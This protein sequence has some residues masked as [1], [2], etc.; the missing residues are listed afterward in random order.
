MSGPSQSDI[1]KSSSAPRPELDFLG[2]VPSSKEQG[3]MK[4]PQEQPLKLANQM[5]GSGCRSCC[6]CA[7]GCR[8]S[9]ST[10]TPGTQLHP[11]HTPTARGE[12]VNGC[13]GYR[14]VCS[15]DTLSLPSQHTN[16]EVLWAWVSSGLCGDP[17]WVEPAQDTAQR[18]NQQLWGRTSA[19]PGCGDF[20]SSRRPHRT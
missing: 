6:A 18:G 2:R 12:Q 17:S 11:T 4:V 15:C 5:K 14:H 8:R 13:P 7:H 10:R 20:L 19:R 9:H 3:A 1:V 16:H